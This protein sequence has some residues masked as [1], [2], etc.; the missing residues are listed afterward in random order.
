MFTD[1]PDGQWPVVAADPV[2]RVP[3]GRVEPPPGQVAYARIS[4]IGASPHSKPIAWSTERN[5]WSR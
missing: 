2:L 1:Q 5:C 4:S 3:I